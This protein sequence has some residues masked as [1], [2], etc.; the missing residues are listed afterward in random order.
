MF[1]NNGAANVLVQAEGPRLVLLLR[2]ADPV[3]PDIFKICPKCEIERPWESSEAE[4]AVAGDCTVLSRN[5][6]SEK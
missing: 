5:S 3:R 2:R 4:K 1:S 6:I